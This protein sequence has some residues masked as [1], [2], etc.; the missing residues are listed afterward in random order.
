MSSRIYERFI[1]SVGR[2]RLAVAVDMPGFGM[3]D[4]P[5]GPPAIADYARA[6]RAA[7]EALGADRPV[8]VMGY[9]TG[10]MI[11]ADLAADHPNL[12]RRVVLVSAPI[13]TDAEQAEM[14]RLYAPIPPALDGSHLLKRWA[15]YVHHN[16]GRGLALE[17]VADMFPEGLLGRRNS[18]WGH[19][20]AFSYAPDMRLTEIGQP[21]L[22][23]NPGDDLQQETRRAAALIRHG[24]LVELPAWGHGFLD[25]FTDD[26]LKLVTSFLDAPDAE[27]FTGLVVP[28]SATGPIRQPKS[29]RI[30]NEPAR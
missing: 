2:A 25:G 18:W 21:I 12:V 23:L 27:P 29:S 22:L 7:I 10:S 30:Q 28:K 4:P 20:S 24:R 19:H 8:D 5:P 15:S 9:H 14:R 3:S 26:A 11:A 6:M 17:D 16:L 1:D 13:F